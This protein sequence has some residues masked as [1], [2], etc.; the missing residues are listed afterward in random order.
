MRE[1]RLRVLLRNAGDMVVSSKDVNTHFNRFYTMRKDMQVHVLH[2]ASLVEEVVDAPKEILL[3]E[4]TLPD[5]Y[6]IVSNQFHNHKNHPLVLK[7]LGLLKKDGIKPVVAFTG[8]VNNPGNEDYVNEINALIKAHDLS[9]QV[10]MLGIIPRQDQL[11]LMKNSMA[12]IQPSLFEG[13]STVIEDAISLQVPVIA[14]N[15][16]VNIE[17]LAEKGFY[18]D[19][20]KAEELADHMRSFLS[21]PHRV[22]YEA[23]HDRMKRF[24]KSFVGIFE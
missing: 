23:Y 17:Q 16:P 7:A 3:K 9:D 20:H 4:Y 15:L 19:P 21:T 5:Q 14:A 13:W 22:E 12:V 1:L 24:A 10:R 8:K 18:F 6:F 2:F 11:R